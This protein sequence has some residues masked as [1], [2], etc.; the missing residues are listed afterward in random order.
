MNVWLVC[1]FAS[2][3]YIGTEPAA[4]VA[5]NVESRKCDFRGV[6]PTK[7]H[8]GTRGVKQDRIAILNSSTYSEER[9]GCVYMVGINQD[10]YGH[11]IYNF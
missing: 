7:S 9:T 6:N 10:M 5:E 1:A 4:G 11:T 2:N 3:S 8:R